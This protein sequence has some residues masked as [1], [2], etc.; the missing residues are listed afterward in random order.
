MSAREEILGRVR[1]ATAAVRDAPAVEVPRGYRT[2]TD[3]G[4]DTFLDR[5]SHMD[6]DVECVE[7]AE[8]DRRVPA[9]LAERGL[10]RVVVP[11]GIP[12]EWVRQVEA[13][14]DDP[15]LDPHALDRADGVLTTCAVAVATTGTIVLDAS[16]GMGR[17]ALS[18][19]PDHHLCVVQAEQLVSSVPEA[20]AALDPR[21]PLTF[22]TGPSATVD[23]EM[24]RVSGVHGPRTLAV[25]VAR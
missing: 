24:E 20:I 18:L 1:A 25:L 16:A 17:R 19:V 8:L 13:L 14:H 9:L 4:L 15:P 7:R 11:D 22:F 23:I 21:R 2:S 6:A 10:H 5:L 3:D 12:G